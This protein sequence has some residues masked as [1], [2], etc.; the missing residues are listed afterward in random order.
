M[1]VLNRLGVKHIQLRALEEAASAEAVNARQGITGRLSHIA[2]GF[3]AQELDQ[4]A[5]AGFFAKVG[6]T[7]S[8]PRETHCC[9]LGLKGNA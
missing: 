7:A 2:C 5:T 8:S 6:L 4:P 3:R 1:C 9:I